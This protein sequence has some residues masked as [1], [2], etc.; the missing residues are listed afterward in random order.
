MMESM[1][2]T[3]MPKMMGFMATMMPNM[4]EIMPRV[5]DEKMIPMIKENPDMKD[6]ML[7]MMQTMFPHCAAN[8]FPLIEKDERI[9]FIKRLYAIMAQSAAVEMDTEAKQS[10]HLESSGVVKDALH[11]NI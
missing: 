3:V 8:M 6:H 7:E 9:A 4:R 10:F 11:T 2:T 1:M 5:M